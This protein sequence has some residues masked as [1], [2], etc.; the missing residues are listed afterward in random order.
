LD[1]FMFIRGYS[2]SKRVPITEEVGAWDPHWR[3]AKRSGSTFWIEIRVGE[4]IKPAPD[5]YIRI[6][7]HKN[8][9]FYHDPSGLFDW[10][11]V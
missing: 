2:R 5:A 6:N 4:E 3:A 1:E 8:Q 10:R 9:V 11:P 7:P